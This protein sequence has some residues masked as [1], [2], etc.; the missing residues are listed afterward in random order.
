MT[1][2]ADFLD[3]R[4]AVVEQSADDRIIDVFPRLVRLCE[5]H[6]NRTLRCREQVSETTLSFSSGSASLPSDFAEA[7]GLYDTNGFEYVQQPLQSVR[8][9]SGT[10]TFYAVGAST[11][12]MSAADSDRTLQYYAKVPT[13]TGSMG[14]S[15]WLLQKHPAVYLYGVGYEA[16]KWRRDVEAAQATRLLLDMEI[17]AANAADADERYSRSRVRVAGATP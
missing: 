12:T 16:E 14:D 9:S 13:I 7:I 17:R 4:T 15:N 6:L 5:A 3:L 10:S 11:I 1:A 2:F 8:V